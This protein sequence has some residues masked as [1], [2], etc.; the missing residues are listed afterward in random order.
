[1]KGLKRCLLFVLSFAVFLTAFSTSFSGKA[2]AA[3][4]TN[5][6]IAN[7]ATTYAPLVKRSW[8]LSPVQT[9]INSANVGPQWRSK[10]NAINSQITFSE[11]DSWVILFNDTSTDTIEIG[12]KKGGDIQGYTEND[13]FSP[14]TNRNR[15]R[16]PSYDSDVIDAWR[17][18]VQS[19][20]I[21]VTNLYTNGLVITQSG[22]SGY[23]ETYGMTYDSSWIVANF[24]E[25]DPET[26]KPQPNQSC[27]P[28]D[29]LCW[30]GNIVGGMANSFQG[31][32]QALLGGIASLFTPDTTTFE[33]QFDELTDFFSEKFGFLFYPIEWLIDM[34]EGII[35]SADNDVAW[36]TSSCGISSLDLGL[37]DESGIQFM[38]VNLPFGTMACNALTFKLQVAT[39]ILFPPLISLALVHAFRQKI[40]ELKV[41]A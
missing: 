20:G 7:W 14:Y 10:I 17:I 9:I 39:R 4:L 29:F 15:L 22:N 23:L 8:S 31:L 13:A 28:L 12:Y 18:V 6:Q 35:G 11:N 2:Y 19:S 25:V 27:N 37:S 21:T 40:H 33:Y 30:V 32:A 1:M 36:G 24:D 16:I 41:K 26:I 3:P 38:G 34:L 5:Y